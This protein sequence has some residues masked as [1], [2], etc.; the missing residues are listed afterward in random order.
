MVA[1]ANKG[2]EPVAQERFVTTNRAIVLSAGA[3]NLIFGAVL[4][5]FINRYIRDIPILIAPEWYDSYWL[6]LFAASLCYAVEALWVRLPADWLY[7]V[8]ITGPPYGWHVALATAIYLKGG[9][10]VAVSEYLKVVLPALLLA[11]S[12]G[13]LNPI[14]A[15]LVTHLKSKWKMAGRG[16]LASGH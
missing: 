2:E 1:A 6:P 11:L 7:G 4:A 13:I 3:I 10:G 8:L 12:G 9:A 15:R 5:L 16:P 14:I